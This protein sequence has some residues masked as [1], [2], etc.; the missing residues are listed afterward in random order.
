MTA[1]AL[2]HSTTKGQCASIAL[3]KDRVSE[4]KNRNLN[5][6]QNHLNRKESLELKILFL[7]LNAGGSVLVSEMLTSHTQLKPLPDSAGLD[8]TQT[9]RMRE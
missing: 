9:S 8:Y 4:Y 6:M 5:W 3:L 1:L 2:L 7:Q